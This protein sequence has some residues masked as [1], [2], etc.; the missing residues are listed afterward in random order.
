[1]IRNILLFVALAL[2]AV[3]LFLAVYVRLAPLD[4]AVWHVDPAA[5]RRTGTP[6]D[7]LVAEGG[8][9]PPV[10]T[11]ESPADVMAR[12]DAVA[13]AAPRVRRL[14]GS[15]EEGFV[16]Y[17][18]RSRLMGFPDAISVRVTPEGAGSQVTIYGRSR[19]GRSDLGV[20]RARVD[21][22]LE[23]AGLE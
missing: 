23:E 7:V 12:M 5:A 8:D 9:R 14:A 1:M 16:T 17:V 2:A 22:W 4:P 15:P 11:A 21:R 18:Q 6:N 20:N 3:G 13:M 10:V 19:F